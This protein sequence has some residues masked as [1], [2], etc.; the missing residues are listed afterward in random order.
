MVGG[1]DQILCLGV[2][3]N[4]TYRQLDI[5]D[6]QQLSRPPTGNPGST[7]RGN[8]G[9]KRANGDKADAN[10]RNQSEPPQ[11][12]D[13]S[14]CF[15]FGRDDSLSGSS[16][17]RAILLHL[18]RISP[19]NTTKGH[20]VPSSSFVCIEPRCGIRGLFPDRTKSERGLRRETLRPSPVS[21][22]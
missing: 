3:W 9:V 4:P 5:Q 12:A 8:T 11:Y 16:W 7:T 10:M 14:V 20:V 19:R 18:C 1:D 13:Y 6:S 21:R 17:H 15:R 22:R 2:R